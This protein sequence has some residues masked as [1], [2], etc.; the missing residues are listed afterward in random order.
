MILLTLFAVDGT[1]LVNGELE[2]NNGYPDIYLKTKVQYKEYTKF[3][4]LIEVKYIKSA[5]KNK[6]EKIK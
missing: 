3:E 4:W 2:N 1:Y 6:L 5:E